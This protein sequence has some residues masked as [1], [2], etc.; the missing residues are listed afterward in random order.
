MK[1]VVDIET[2]STVDLL[3]H[4]TV[5]YASHDSTKICVLS[6]KVVGEK[7]IHTLY[8]PSLALI[9]T[10]K[11]KYQRAV[12]KVKEVFTNENLTLIA[13]NYFFEKTLF[14]HQLH[15]F[16][17]NWIDLEGV[18][19][20]CWNYICTMQ[21]VMSHRKKGALD[22]A[23]DVF[24]L[25]ARKYSTGASLMKNI[26][27]GVKE[28]P[29][30]LES[31]VNGIST[32]WIYVDGYWYKGGKEAY[33][34]MIEYC[35]IDVLVTEQLYKKLKSKKVYGDL[36]PFSKYIK[37][38]M[39]L[40]KKMNEYGL[41]IDMDFLPKLSQAANNI[42][43][44]CEKTSLKHFDGL[45]RN[46][47][48]KITKYLKSV[49]MDINGVGGVDV[50][51][52]KQSEA[53]KKFKTELKALE[54]YNR[55]N[56]AS[57]NKI[58]AI[59]DK[60]VEGKIHNFLTFA[61]AAE[62]GR[63]SGRG[64][65]PQNFPRPSGDY[66]V[67]EIRDLI[68]KN[69]KDKKWCIENVDVIES[70]LRTL[71]IPDFDNQTFFITDLSQI[72]ARITL[73]ECGYKDVV[74]KIAEGWDIYS[75]MATT[76]YKK[77]IK[78]GDWQRNVGKEA[79]LGC[80]FGMSPPKFFK[81]LTE[82]YGKNFIS[83]KEAVKAVGNYRK[84]YKNIPR[85]WAEYDNLIKK[86]FKS[87]TPL[88]IQLKSGRWLNYGNI[89]RK[90]VVKNGK[91]KYQFTYN[92]SGSQRVIYGSLMFQQ[93]VQATARD[94]ML[95]KMAEM[96][97][98]GYDTKLTVHDEAVY[99]VDKCANLNKLARDWKESGAEVLEKQFKG[100]KIDSDCCLSDTYFSH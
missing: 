90:K 8:L 63:W 67:K 79:I 52:A 24:N 94:I 54:K 28:K 56:K 4:D 48:V 25:K 6:F 20:S 73:Y 68:N 78:K 66:K 19:P 15:K 84:K 77:K 13:H 1:V 88:K 42:I 10:T 93:T 58:Q 34:K 40:T 45:S 43:A 3:K 30:K 36:K 74:D 14:I 89:E 17:K 99:Q 60:Q 11:P 75:D 46:Q 38:G 18:Y 100:L 70:A 55:L 44:E 50:L 98:K 96:A 33:E 26:C 82:R 51:A 9:D 27:K 97:D 64:V 35:E 76:I 86:H 95:I 72:E 59:K 62:T 57:F 12:K 32:Q 5:R 85:K 53:N 29:K 65:Q 7:E 92:V 47:R 23:A 16:L 49:G 69:Y 21:W 2:I 37:A 71:V 80:G 31:T 83:Y 91:T 41:R 81:T 39:E 87:K 61:G 22:K